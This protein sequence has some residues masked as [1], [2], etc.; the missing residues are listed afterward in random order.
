MGHNGEGGEKSDWEWC[1]KFKNK[2]AKR[3]KAGLELNVC[4]SSRED[5]HAP[6]AVPR[7]LYM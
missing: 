2:T 4:A 1:S 7:L 3:I 5:S 6:G